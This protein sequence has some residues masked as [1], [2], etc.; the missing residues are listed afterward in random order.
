MKLENEDIFLVIMTNEEKQDLLI[1]Q[2]E[3]RV[4]NKCQ[5][6]MSKADYVGLRFAG[7][8][9][10]NEF[11]EPLYIFLNTLRFAE[12]VIFLSNLQKKLRIFLFD[13]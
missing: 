9:Y 11:A 7:T 8:V 1:F 2:V 3:V 4:E 12:H 10:S 6:L 5:S 13:V